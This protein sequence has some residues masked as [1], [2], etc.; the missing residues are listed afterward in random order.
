MRTRR[1]EQKLE[2]IEACSSYVE[3]R[4]DRIRTAIA[5]L[6]DALKLETK[7]S[8]GDKYETGRAMLH[9]EFE[10]L[11]GQL[12]QYGQLKKT[13]G[14]LRG[15][16]ATEIVGFGSAVETSGS[17]YLIAIP[18]GKLKPGGKDFFAV[19]VSSPIA[20]ALSGKK[21]GDSYSFNGK[22]EEILDIF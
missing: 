19:G 22:E 4:I 2:L 7:C 10:K 6:E 21:K 16:P 13:L 3:E 17:N 12:E 5:D 1:S 9:L 18:A 11:S 14:I 15:I 20:K 8:M